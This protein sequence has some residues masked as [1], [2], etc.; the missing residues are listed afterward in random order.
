MATQLDWLL[1]RLP[2]EISSIPISWS[3]FASPSY[4]PLWP[5]CSPRF[6]AWLASLVARG[7]SAAH[8]LV[9]SPHSL[10]ADRIATS[11]NHGTF[12]PLAL[13]SC[14]TTQPYKRAVQLCPERA[15]F[16][17]RDDTIIDNDGYLGDPSKVKLLPS[18]ATALT[19]IRALGYR[20]IVVSNQSGVA[21]GMFSE[22]SVKAVNDEMSRQLKEKAGAYIDASYYCPFHPEAK[23]A[24]YRA[25]H[26]W[27][28]PKPGMILQAAADFGLELSQ[29]WMIGD[30]AR[31]ITAAASA[32]CTHG[33]AQGSR[34]PQKGRGG[35]ITSDE[36]FPIA[37]NFI[38]KTLNADAARIIV[39]EGPNPPPPPPPQQA[40]ALPA[41]SS[42]GPVSPTL[43]SVRH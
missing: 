32:G 27:R 38:V 3:P 34:S 37:P 19:A 41:A 21:R 36:T 42:P 26:Q 6:W 25:D 9:L 5:L 29:C 31:D 35:G 17:D 39:R 2:D 43:S 15:V 22:D 30:M 33:T 23:V 28:K 13:Q 12:P 8:D 20:L 7:Q 10:A 24:E 4:S 18:A 14:F 40:P 11:D 1:H 16:L